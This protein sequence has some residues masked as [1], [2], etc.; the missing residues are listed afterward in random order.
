MQFFNDLN[1]FSVSSDTIVTIG[2][3]DGIH[4]GHDFIFNQLRQFGKRHQLKTVVVSFYPH[5]SEV[6]R[7]TPVHLLSSPEEKRLL[8]EKKGID[9]FVILNFT[10]ELSQLTYDVFVQKILIETLRMKFLLVGYDHALG[11]NRQGTFNNLHKLSKTLNFG[12]AKVDPLYKG[13]LLLSSSAIRSEIKKG[14][15]VKAATYLGRFYSI[16]GKVV[17]GE[18]RGRVLEFPTANVKPLE[19][20]KLVPK[21][22]VYLVKTILKDQSFFG[23]CNIGVNPTFDGTEA[24]IEVHIF[25]FKKTIYGQE[26]TVEFLNFIRTEKKFKSADELKKQ[27]RNDEISCRLLIKNA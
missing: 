1:Q 10:K 14:D 9:A 26:I 25:D 8:M 6:V 18:K 22:G 5:P 2:S 24:K 20:R 21:Q 17:D 4:P 15:V 7:N 16:S 27:L 13:E 3:F 23:M 12:I 19:K 11:K